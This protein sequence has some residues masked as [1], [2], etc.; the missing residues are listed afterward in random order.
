MMFSRLSILNELFLTLC[1]LILLW[2]YQDITS[3]LSQGRCVIKRVIGQE[4][5]GDL[6]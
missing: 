6:P 5:Q 4:P 2:V 3:L 1:I